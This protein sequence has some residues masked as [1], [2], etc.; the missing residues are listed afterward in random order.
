MGTAREL[1]ACLY[2]RG[3]GSMRRGG[4]GTRQATCPCAGE[5]HNVGRCGQSSREAVGR[6]RGGSRRAP[7]AHRIEQRS[8]TRGRRGQER[9]RRRWL[10]QLTVR[11]LAR[12]AEEENE[13]GQRSRGNTT[14]RGSC[15]TLMARPEPVGAAMPTGTVARPPFWLAAHV[16][17]TGMACFGFFT[18]VSSCLP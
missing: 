9:G 17:T 10:Q 11:S 1:G 14:S 2:S 8:R 3:E 16:L 6:R 15:R 4:G 5:G 13:W 7:E 12:L 18:D